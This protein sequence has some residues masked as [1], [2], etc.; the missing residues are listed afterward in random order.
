MH[1]ANPQNNRSILIYRVPELDPGHS[2]LERG[3]RATLALTRFHSLLRR[4]KSGVESGLSLTVQQQQGP[5]EWPLWEQGV[6][7]PAEGATLR[8]PA[9]REVLERL[10]TG[11]GGGVTPPP[12]DPPPSDPDF[13]VESNGIYK[14][15]YCV[16]LFLEQ[17]FRFQTPP[18]LHPPLV[19]S[20]P[21]A[22]LACPPQIPL[23]IMEDRLLGSVDVE[24]SVRQG[25]TVFQP[26]LLA[27]AH[28]GILYVDDINLLDDELCNILLSSLADG[29]VNVE[30]EVRPVLRVAVENGGGIRCHCPCPCL[31][32]ACAPCRYRSATHVRIGGGLSSPGPGWSPVALHPGR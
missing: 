9:A 20:I 25:K 14:R 31:L 17:T 3:L 6:A 4:Q 27:K 29:W 30:R 10:T 7:P 15:K 13:T 12:L 18:P 1:P 5:L 11:G 2:V 24:E 8:Q 23:N 19:H 26:G 22:A 16:G 21:R 32:T 28:R